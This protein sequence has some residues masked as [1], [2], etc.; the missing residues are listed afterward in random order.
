MINLKALA[1]TTLITLGSAT[2]ALALAYPG[3]NSGPQGGGN[4]TIS[5][6]SRFPGYCHTAQEAG[7]YWLKKDGFDCRTTSRTNSN[8][9][10]VWDI[11]DRHG[12]KTTV[13]L[14]N[15]GKADVIQSNGTWKA[16]WIRGNDGRVEI[17]SHESDYSMAFPTR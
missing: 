17:Y 13:V 15:D 9:H 8:G 3:Q 10:K 6:P 5:N 16:D 2:P 14:W 1:L 12:W 11:V 4:P 7:D